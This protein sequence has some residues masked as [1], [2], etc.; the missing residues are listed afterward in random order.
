M[1]ANITSATVQGNKYKVWDDFSMRCTLAEN[2]AGEIKKI[3][4]FGYISK[5][6]T[7][8]KAIANCFGHNSF[9]K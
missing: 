5:D 7:I 1:K 2:E 3:R 6:L 8:R 4:E 9:R